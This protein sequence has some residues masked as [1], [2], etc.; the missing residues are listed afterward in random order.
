MTDAPDRT[1]VFPNLYV[2][3]KDSEKGFDGFVI[4]VREEAPTDPRVLH[5]PAFESLADGAWRARPVLA[6]W[7]V[8]TIANRLKAGSRVLIRSGSGVERS[9]A[10]AVLYLVRYQ[11]LS[12]SEAYRRIRAARPQ[13][14]E[15]FDLLPLTFEE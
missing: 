10:I 8:T 2:G 9:P 7:A 14:I 11:G 12:P 3:G 13:V 4:D 15:E 1:E 5:I 6:E